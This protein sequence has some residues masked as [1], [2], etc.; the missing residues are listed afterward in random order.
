MPVPGCPNPGAQL[1]DECPNPEK[2]PHATTTCSK[3]NVLKKRSSLGFLSHRGDH[4][5][6]GTEVA[7]PGPKRG[8]MTTCEA[9]IVVR[10]YEQS[11]THFAPAGSP[12]CRH[13]TLHV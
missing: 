3:N 8:L 1:P 4:T 6:T 12:S 13:V 2:S 11:S 5:C 10:S 7:L 9:R